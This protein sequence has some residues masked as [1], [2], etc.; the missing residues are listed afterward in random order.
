MW[1]GQS[2]ADNQIQPGVPFKRAGT[3]AFGFITAADQ[4]RLIQFSLTL[5]LNKGFTK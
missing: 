4:G 5:K 3:G 1:T 2:A